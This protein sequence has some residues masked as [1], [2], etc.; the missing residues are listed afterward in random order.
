MIASSS[1]YNIRLVF[2]CRQLGRRANIPPCIWRLH[3]DGSNTGDAE[4]TPSSLIL[5][6]RGPA[7]PDVQQRTVQLLTEQERLISV[8]VPLLSPWIYCEIFIPISLPQPSSPNP[9]DS[10][11]RG[12]LTSINPKQASCVSC[13]SR[14]NVTERRLSIRLRNCMGPVLRGAQELDCLGG[15]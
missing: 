9:S 5:T 12:L 2:F 7:V 1:L 3:S 13:S 11:V 14:S 10:D 4:A 8:P 15:R 6:D